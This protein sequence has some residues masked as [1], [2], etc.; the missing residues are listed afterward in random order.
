MNGKTDSVAVVDDLKIVS[1]KIV[2]LNGYTRT[3][4]P[5]K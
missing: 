4:K 5:K 3:L 2:E 1:G